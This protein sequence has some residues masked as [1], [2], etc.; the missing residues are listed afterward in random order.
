M[1]HV[2]LTLAVLSLAISLTAPAFAHGPKGI[3]LDRVEDRI[4]RREDIRDRRVNLGPVDRIEDRFDRV[5][6]RSDRR[7]HRRVPATVILRHRD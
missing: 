5:E 6:N 3:P 4:D 7:D 1:K 2:P